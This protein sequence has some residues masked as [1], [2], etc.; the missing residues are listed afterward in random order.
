MAQPQTVGI[1]KFVWRPESS[2]EDLMMYLFRF[3]C[4]IKSNQVDILIEEESIEASQM[5]M[6]YGGNDIM[7]PL[8]ATVTD[9][10]LL[11]VLTYQQTKALLIRKY[12]QTNYKFNLVRLHNRKYKKIY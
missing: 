6:A 1:E 3:E 11:K 10:E 8:I 5:L 7:N 2:T 4:F 9:W 12:V